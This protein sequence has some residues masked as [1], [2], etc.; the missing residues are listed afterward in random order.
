M[1]AWVDGTHRYTVRIR[2]AGGQLDWSCS[3]PL[4]DDAF[5]G[6]GQLLR[7]IAAVHL[8]ACTKSTL[9]GERA[10]ERQFG[11]LLDD[12]WGE[13]SAVDYRRALGE[14][15]R[16]R[17]ARLVRAEWDKLPGLKPGARGAHGS[18]WRS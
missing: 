3:C 4:G 18:G 5:A 2:A 10:A 11:L 9:V 1:T 16:A 7:R 17:F 8:G 12:E 13:L 14:V 15:G 6:I